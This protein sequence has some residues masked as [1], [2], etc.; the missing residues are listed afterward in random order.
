MFQGNGILIQSSYGVYQHT[1]LDEAKCL[2]AFEYGVC[3]FAKTSSYGNFISLLNIMVTLSM[4]L[5]K[6]A[7]NMVCSVPMIICMMKIKVI[8]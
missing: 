2:F 6:F 7:K 8:S 3:Q 4:A 1:C 5:V